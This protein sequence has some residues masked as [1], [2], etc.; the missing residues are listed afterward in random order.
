MSRRI[1]FYSKSDL[2]IYSEFQKAVEM[3]M[4]LQPDSYSTDSLTDVIELFNIKKIFENVKLGENASKEIKDFVKQWLPYFNPLIARNLNSLDEKGILNE[5]PSI[6]REYFKSTLELERMFKK[7][8]LSSLTIREVLESHPYFIGEILKDKTLVDKHKKLLH[9]FFITFEDAAVILMKETEEKLFLKGLNMQQSEVNSIIEKYLSLPFPDLNTIRAIRFHKNTENVRIPASLLLKAEKIEENISRTIAIDKGGVSLRVSVITSDFQEEA[10]V[11]VDDSE[12]RIEFSVN[13]ELVKDWSFQE[14]RY[15]LEMFDWN[16]TFSLIDHRCYHRIED[17]L[18]ILNPSAKHIFPL[19]ISYR[20]RNMIIGTLFAAVV[21]IID[22]KGIGYFETLKEEYELTLKSKYAYPSLPLCSPSMG[23]TMLEKLRCV[24]PEIE[25][26]LHQFTQY[27]ETGNIDAEL[28]NLENFD[29]IDKTPSIVPDNLVYLS[30]N[31]DLQSIFYILFGNHGLV[32]Q[33]DKETQYNNIFEFV[34]SK[35]MKGELVSTTHL[36]K[37]TLQQLRILKDNDFLSMSDGMIVPKN[38][39][40]WIVYRYIYDVGAI[41]LYR[42]EVPIIQYLQK[43]IAE[44]EYKTEKKLFTTQEC[45][46][47]S[48]FL[49]DAK[50]TNGLKLRNKYM[51]GKGGYDETTMRGDYLH[52][53]Y[54]LTLIIARIGDNLELYKLTQGNKNN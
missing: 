16:G 23:A 52:I 1:T 47:L 9:D 39:E 41:H 53:L 27:S 3:L 15:Y 17:E 38:I 14:I 42:N 20:F 31:D 33:L 8:I 6:S 34:T 19:P 11:L 21:Q 48:Y 4:D 35:M 25:N 51:H 13:P 5:I 12:G 32:Y 49:N 40:K 10:L 26:I 18:F 46:Y 45:D 22:D 54:I 28:L 30:Q 43:A 36:D 44:G 2:T 7:P 50:F 24:I 37:S 29:S